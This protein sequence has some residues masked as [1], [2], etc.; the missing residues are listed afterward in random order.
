MPVSVRIRC[1]LQGFLA[2]YLFDIDLEVSS[3][4]AAPNKRYLIAIGRKSGMEYASRKTGEGYDL[5]R[6]QR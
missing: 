4:F 6:R 1:D 2:A 3:L 5:H